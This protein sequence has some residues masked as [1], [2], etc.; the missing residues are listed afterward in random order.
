MSNSSA[1]FL[2]WKAGQ[3]PNVGILYLCM[4][5]CCGLPFLFKFHSLRNVMKDELGVDDSQHWL[6]VII[7]IYGFY[8]SEK[9]L[10]EL[11]A[12]KGITNQSSMPLW[13]SIILFFLWPVKLAEMMNRINVLVAAKQQ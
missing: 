7:G 9:Q 6:L 13:V 5:C 10:T 8:V 2:D 12:S 3:E 4:C 1:G 11:E